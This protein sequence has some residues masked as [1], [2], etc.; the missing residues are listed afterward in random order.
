[1]EFHLLADLGG[2][3][4]ESPVWDD[5]RNCLFLCDI[6]KGLI[7]AVTLT[8]AVRTWDLD[9]PFVNALGLCDSGWLVV[10]LQRQVILFD[11]DSGARRLLWDG[12]DEIAT[13]RL[14]D[15]KVG[16]DGAFWVGSM[17]GREDRADISRLYRITAEGRGDVV[18]QGFKTSNGLAW[19]ADAAV[20]FHS[21]SMGPW[22]DRYDFDAATGQATARRRIRDL[23]Q[24]TGR[25]DGGATS[26]D[27]S[28]WSAGAFAGILNRFDAEGALLGRI[29]L[30]CSAPTMPCFCG[31]DLGLLA[32][33]ARRDPAVPGVNGG[34][35]L[36]ESP[37]PGVPVHRMAGC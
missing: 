11:P 22:I 31:P 2:D 29:A 21:D 9:A 33:T 13:S 27:G 10:A 8:G 28:Y 12:F 6:P 18:A 20:M 19:S 24:A 3:L 30:P 37:V 1:M 4:P 16:P 17:D 7:H 25:P 23:D 14:N 26:T 34:V 36:A 5:R 15:G 35:W 32:L